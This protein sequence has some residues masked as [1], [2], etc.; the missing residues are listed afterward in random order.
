MAR[1]DPQQLPGGAE[2]SAYAN[3]AEISPGDAAILGTPTG[4]SPDRDSDPQSIF[5]E[6]VASI[7][8]GA[9]PMSEI[10]GDPEPGTEHE[11]VDGLDEL[12]ESV[13][14][15]AEDSPLGPPRGSF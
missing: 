15:A 13:R 14:Q 8:V 10:T 11:T 7:P 4:E 5:D 12:E 2:R 1:R 6:E 3:Q 9:R